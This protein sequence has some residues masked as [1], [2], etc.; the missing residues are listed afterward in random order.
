MKKLRKR[1]HPKHFA[2][3]IF[4]LATL[5]GR[6]LK[7]EVKQEVPLDSIPGGK[8][9]AGWHGQ[10]FLPAIY[11]RDK[12]VWTIISLSRDGEMQNRIFKRFGFNIIRGS[13]GRNGIRAAVEAMRKLK[14]GCSLAFTPDGPRGPTRQIQDGVL[15]MAQK[16]GAAIIPCGNSAKRAWRAKSWDRYMIPKVRSKAVLIFGP[17]IYI[18]PGSGEVGLQEARAKLEAEINRLQNQAEHEMGSD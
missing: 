6:T 15:H 11:F 13:T 2:A 1:V 3:A 12:G 8:I 17:P 10:T 14:E 18:E 9:F 4:R 16:T 7:L 5:I